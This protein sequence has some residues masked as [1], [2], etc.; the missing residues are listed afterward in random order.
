MARKYGGGVAPYLLLL[1]L[2]VLILFPLSPQSVIV[3]FG[4]TVSGEK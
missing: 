3:W 2:V 4:F 1:L